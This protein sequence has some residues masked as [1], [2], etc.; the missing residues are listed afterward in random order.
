MKRLFLALVLTLSTGVIFAQIPNDYYKNAE[1]KTSDE[2]KNALHDIIKGHYVVSYAD[3]LDAFAYTDCDANNKIVDI[4]SNYHYSLNGN[5][6]EY[7]EEGDCWNR[8]H[9]WPQSWFNEKNG[10]RSDL[11]HVYPTDGYVNGRRS[12]YPYGEVSKPTYT[13]GNGS[14]LGPCTTTGY[15]GTVFEPID[16][17]KGDIARG[18]FYMSV[19]YSGEDSGWKT[20]DMTNKSTI[21][22]WAMS[23]LLRWNDADPV[24]QK[25]IDRNNAVY[26]YQKN[27]N[28]FIDHPEYARMIWDP[29]YVPATSYEITYANVQQ[30]VVSGPTS[31]PQG[32]T[33]AI[34]ATP[35]PGFM[36]DTYTVYKTDSPSTTVPVSTNGS[37][38][39]PGYRVTVSAS[40]VA[41]NTPYDITKATVTH[42]TINTSA[43]HATPGT[44]ITLDAH[45]NSGYQLYA[46]YV[47]KTGD[48]NTTVQ[49]T[50]DSFTMPGFHVTVNATFVNNNSGGN[51]V[52]VTSNLADWSGEYLIVYEEGL[53]AFNGELTA[54]DAVSNFIDITTNNG[55]IEA[56]TSTNK[57]KFTIAKSGNSYSI[58]SASGYYIGRTGS[59][60]GL[61]TSQTQVY[62]N[63]LS[64]S[65]NTVSVEGSYGTLKFNNT[66]GQKRFR[67]YGSGQE[68]IQLYKKEGAGIP[69]HS[70]HFDPNGGTGT[71]TDQTVYEFVPTTLHAN[72]FNKPDSQF[73]GWNTHTDGTGTYYVDEGD[74]TLLSDLALYAQWDPLYSITVSQNVEHGAIEAD[75]LQAIEEQTV[76]LT[77][78]PDE[79]Y[80]L[81]HWIVKDAANNLV[82]VE[83]NQFEMPASNVTVSAVFVFVGVPYEQK[84][85]LVTSTDQLVA[86][87]TYLIVNTEHSKALS[88]T[89]NNN[90]RAAE[91]VVI[92]NNVISDLGDACE[93]TLGGQT[94]SWTFFDANWSTTGG[95]LFAA[96][97]NNNYLRTRATN[98]DDNNG[99]WKVEISSID[100]K[101]T[102]TAQGSNSH[103]MLRYNSE[104]T[105]FSCYANGQNDVFL[106]IRS[107]EIDITENTTLNKVFEF[108]KYTVHSG[109]TLTLGGTPVVSSPGNLVLE[110]GAQLLHHCEGVQATLRKPIEGYTGKGGWYTIASPFVSYSPTGG[111]ISNDFDLYAY[112]ES[113]DDDGYE[114]IN[115]K[116]DAFDLALGKGYLYACNPSVN[117]RFSGLLNSG[118]YSE[119]VNLGY[120]NSVIDLRGFNLL[121][122]PTAHDIVFTKSGQ[123]SDGYYYLDNDE[124]WT[125]QTGDVVPVG[126]GFLVKANAPEQTVTLNPQNRETTHEADPYLCLDIDGEKAYV[127]LGEGVSMP[128]AK[129]DDRY[130]PLFLARGKT[131]YVM[132]VKDS[133][134]TVDMCYEARRNGVSTL[135]VNVQGLGLDYL[136][137]IDHRTGADIDL[138]VTPRYDFETRKGDYAARFQLRFAPVPVEDTQDDFAYYSDGQLVFDP[139]VVATCQGASLQLV[140]MLGRVMGLGTID[141]ASQV[142]VGKD[143]P[144]CVPAAIAGVYVLRLLNGDEV[145]TQKI[146]LY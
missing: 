26:G 33:V 141:G 82:A 55:I 51:Y 17:Y 79:G 138:L 113:G 39:M 140:D 106:F 91:E 77:A 112:H 38:T 68:D 139:V 12:N 98:D 121:G 95:Y 2:L 13:S 89:Q 73:D 93:L 20:S 131:S 21:K 85:Y 22:P 96:S 9:T 146:V 99:K 69:T 78:T 50:N 142:I 128:L 71:M 145:R 29:N 133:E 102:L 18:F 111:M 36:V 70:I 5:C 49:V 54:L 1:G 31:A 127:K 126:R 117:L 81:D 25:E 143:A 75:V 4:Y 137:L 28:P 109:A 88:K 10:P 27:R 15:S 7:H 84:Y 48:M 74:V 132:L 124:T 123:V 56:N 35:T 3:L 135:S 104:S 45:P 60:N 125:Y 61:N 66:S 144:G 58:K 101:A 76:T 53:K 19:R 63:T 108:D 129:F 47:Y 16:E 120:A 62:D 87:R 116:E 64:Y 110:E 105:L 24:S 11:F 41:N 8:E 114:W 52:K 80:E 115:Y 136:H 65:N 57:A 122:N 90:N 119:T 43:D 46:W 94:G 86:G 42:G 44:N 100:G 32:S 23:M 72:A 37:F 92:T 83:D 118:D 30:G 103:N 40:F 107:E 97:S 67:Y 134:N 6:G 59:S 130:S 14:K 34:V